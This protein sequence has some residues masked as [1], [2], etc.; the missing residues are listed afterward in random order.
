MKRKYDIFLV[1]ADG[2][3]LDFHAS[4]L[5]SLKAAFKAFKREWKEEYKEEFFSLNDELWQKLERKEI[6]RERLLSSRFPEF[7]DRVGE[8]DIPGDKFNEKYIAYLSR[9]PQYYPGAEEFLDKLRSAGKVYI[10]TNGTYAVQSSRFRICGLDKK[11][12]GI[13]VSEKIGC[14]KPGEAYTE[15]VVSHIPGFDKRRAVWI[16]D[17]VTADISAANAAGID[18]V[19]FNPDNLDTGGKGF[20]DYEGDSYAEILEILQIS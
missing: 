15:Y 4:S 14:D 5:A 16:G 8:D 13:F 2:T 3:L 6:T 20:P 17:S 1:D 18:S 12:D 7:L 9:H 19:W 11:A 10:V